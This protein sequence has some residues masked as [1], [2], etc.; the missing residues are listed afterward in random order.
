MTLL[1]TSFISKLPRCH[2]YSVAYGNLIALLVG[3]G[4]CNRNCSAKFS[5]HRLGSQSAPIRRRWVGLCLRPEVMTNH[6]TMLA[7]QAFS[8]G[9][10]RCVEV[11][12][13]QPGPGELLV[14][15]ESASICGSDLHMA[16]LGW[17]IP[18]WPAPPGH[19][20]H[21]AA[22]TV[23]ESRGRRFKPGDRVL[24]APRIW[25]SR[26]FAEFQNID[27][28][29]VTP[30]P[31][32]VAF[33]YATMAQ[34]LGT[35]IYAA[36]RLTGRSGCSVRGCGDRVRPGAVLELRP[37]EKR[38]CQSDLRRTGRASQVGGIA[39]RFGRG[40]RLRDSPD[41]PKPSWRLLAALERTSWWRR[42]ARRTR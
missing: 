32:D 26:C 10:I 39:L 2:A 22:G 27:E 5:E 41:G 12:V 7:A 25:D 1:R 37:Q 11:A 35:V 15:T 4:D 20:G 24:T 19:P 13:P 14:R 38:R 16:L 3:W 18:S 34:Q 36:R 29:Y 23:V 31:D 42:W 17:G 6:K 40:D 8:Q 33:E 21:E 30:L 28:A 9:D